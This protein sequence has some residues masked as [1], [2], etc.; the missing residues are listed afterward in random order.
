MMNK[1][2][3]KIVQ[4]VVN[5]N[6]TI[7]VIKLSNILIVLKYNNTTNDYFKL[8]FLFILVTTIMILSIIIFILSFHLISIILISNIDKLIDIL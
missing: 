5:Y 6:M 7:I 2:W 3:L 4:L 1:Q 8:F